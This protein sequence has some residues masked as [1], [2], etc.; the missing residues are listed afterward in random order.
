MALP[1]LN[2]V[3]KYQIQVPST[4]N[5]VTYRPFLVKEEKVL[6]LALESEDTKQIARAI[7]DTVLACV[8]ENLNENELTGY[9]IEYLFLNI[10]GKSV[11]ETSQ[12]TLK[13]TNCSHENPV[14]VDI[15][16]IEMAHP[17]KEN[18]IKINDQIS[19]EMRQPSFVS[20][21]KNKSVNSDKVSDQIFG[22]IQESIS[23]ILTEDE[24]ISVADTPIEEFQEFI[25]SM[26]GAQFAKIREYVEQMPTVK[27]DVKYNCESCGTAHEVTIQGMQNFL[28]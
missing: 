22:L 4:G 12:I 27:T 20:L 13:C 17:P 16:D 9:D 2:D 25:E 6:L 14:T 1:K 8:F 19:L 18:I 24:R 7:L 28:S 26:T 3:P 10:R 23:A 15:Q 21:T 5:E 11:G